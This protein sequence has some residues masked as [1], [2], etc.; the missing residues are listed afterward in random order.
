MELK[1]KN[2]DPNKV[3]SI[4]INPMDSLYW[5]NSKNIGLHSTEPI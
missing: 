3:R 1:S 4:W 5:Q 2:V